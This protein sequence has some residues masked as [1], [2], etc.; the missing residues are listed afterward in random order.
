MMVVR[1]LQKSRLNSRG[2]T[3]IEI[4]IAMA[5][6][7]LVL[8]TAYAISTQSLRTGTAAG[9]RSQ[10]LGYAQSQVEYIKQAVGT[11][12]NVKLAL[13]TSST[14][15]CVDPNGNYVAVPG[16]SLPTNLCLDYDSIGIPYSVIVVYDV[17]R[18]VF[19]VNVKWLGANLSAEESQLTLYYKLPGGFALPPSVTTNFASNI[20]DRFMTLNGEVNPN[21]NNVTSCFFLFNTSS[22]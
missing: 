15:F 6:L 10:A 1:L 3:I 19:T 22:N 16:G 4:L 21:G 5:I 9:Q 18:Q 17:G 12:D 8:S 2:D 20:G 14:P 13:Y 7:A 11:R